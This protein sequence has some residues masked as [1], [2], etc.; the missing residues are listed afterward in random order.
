MSRSIRVAIAALILKSTSPKLDHQCKYDVVLNDCV[1][2]GFTGE[3]IQLPERSEKLY[4]LAFI[5][6]CL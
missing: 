5:G 4:D 3:V 1:L 2:K 6:C